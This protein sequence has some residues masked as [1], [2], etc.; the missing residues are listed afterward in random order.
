MAAAM[1]QAGRIV[2]DEEHDG[3]GVGDDEDVEDE[4]T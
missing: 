2:N 1:L 4:E 3:H